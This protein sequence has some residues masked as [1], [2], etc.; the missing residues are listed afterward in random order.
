MRQ[1]IR[2]DPIGVT[3]SSKANIAFIKDES[4][5]KA[6][7]NFNPKSIEGYNIELRA[8]ISKDSNNKIFIKGLKPNVT[9]SEL[10]KIFSIFGKVNE[11]S[12]KKGYAVN[13][14]VGFD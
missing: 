2:V 13:A 4:Y 14:I 7:K 10:E 11:R 12:I 9:E 5:E 8:H 3:N 1:R 6:F